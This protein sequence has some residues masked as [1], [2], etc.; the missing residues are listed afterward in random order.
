MR[1]NTLY[2]VHKLEKHLWGKIKEYEWQTNE[3]ARYPVRNEELAEASMLNFNMVLALVRRVSEEQK[4][5]LTEK[6]IVKGQKEVSP[7]RRT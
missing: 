4:K 3:T 1:F 7:T 6:T 2:V 5:A